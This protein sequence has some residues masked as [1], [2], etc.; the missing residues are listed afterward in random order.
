VLGTSP[1]EVRME[2]IHE[3]SDVAGHG[4]VEGAL[5]IV[6]FDHAARL[7]RAQRRIPPREHRSGR[8]RRVCPSD[9]M[10]YPLGV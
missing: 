6:R 1:L 4:L 10:G 7:H 3:G 5:E 8:P 2:Q 9:D